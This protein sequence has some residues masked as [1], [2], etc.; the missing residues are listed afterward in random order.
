MKKLPIEIQYVLLA[1]DVRMEENGKHFIIGLYNDQVVIPRE[2]PLLVAPL[3]FFIMVK[4]QRGKGVHTTTWIE[5]PTG[6][7]M[8]ESD[9]G[10]LRLPDEQSSTLGQILWR[11]LP[12]RSEG[13]GK[14]KLHM[15]QDGHDS[16]IH[17]FELKTN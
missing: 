13:L 3:T 5:G 8:Q 17:E 2:T 10:E 12:W 15:V 11:I 9:W 7:R 16:V 1:D 4:F 6:Q 14:Y